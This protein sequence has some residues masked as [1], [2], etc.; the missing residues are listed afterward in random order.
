M[1]MWQAE[2]A[3][4]DYP[5]TNAFVELVHQLM[6]SP[7]HEE[8]RSVHGAVLQPALAELCMRLFTSSHCWQGSDNVADPI[9]KWRLA[10]GM[11][12]VLLDIF[13]LYQA[14]DTSSH[15]NS[16][17]S[18][19]GWKAILND[20]DLGAALIKILIAVWRPMVKYEWCVMSEVVEV[21]LLLISCLLSSNS[22]ARV[23]LEHIT[24]GAS[25]T[26]LREANNMRPTLTMFVREIAKYAD[27]SHYP[28]TIEILALRI[29]RQLA[30][31]CIHS[32]DPGRPSYRLPLHQVLSAGNKDDVPSWGDLVAKHCHPESNPRTASSI[33]RLARSATQ[34]GNA[35]GQLLCS[36]APDHELGDGPQSVATP[37]PS[38]LQFSINKIRA[39]KQLM[40]NHPELVLEA[41]RLVEVVGKQKS[42]S[43]LGSF[44]LRFLENIPVSLQEIDIRNA[45]YDLVKAGWSVIASSPCE[46]V[47]QEID[48]DVVSHCIFNVMCDYR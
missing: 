43:S 9:S 2:C 1:S 19:L 4:G 7:V 36:V 35:L 37:S 12:V 25:Q 6:R 3:T 46:G 23:L 31:V 27:G 20:L 21:L 8:W 18:T 30:T 38:L 40:T 29:L 26:V 10:H 32:Q 48:L 22:L 33:L 24:S 15:D 44:M 42:K 16:C 14:A 13:T 11:L 47:V 39:H 28:M 5:A 34:A 17:P 45:I 41:L